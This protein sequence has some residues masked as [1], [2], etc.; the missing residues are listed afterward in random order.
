MPASSFPSSWPAAPTNGTPCLSSW[1]PGASPTN[2]RS[3]VGEPE[4]KTTCVRRLRERAARAAGD[5]VARTRRAVSS[6]AG[7]GVSDSV[8]ATA[9]AAAA[10]EPDRR[11]SC[12]GVAVL[13]VPVSAANTENC[14]CTFA[15]PQSGHVGRLVVADELLEVRLAAHADV[16]VD[17]HRGSNRTKPLPV[18]SHRASCAPSRRTATRRYAARCPVSATELEPEMKTFATIAELRPRSRRCARATVGLVPTMGALHDGHVALFEAARAECDVVVASLF[19]N[20]AQFATRRPRRVPARPRRATSASPR[21]RVSTSSS[22]RRPTS[23]IRPASRPGSSRRGA[24][25]GLE[26]EHRPGHFRGVATVCLK[27]FTIVRP[28]RRVLRPQGR[29]AGRGREAGRARPE[30]RARDPRRPDRARRRRARALVAQRAALAPTSARARSRSRARSRRA[31][32][33]APARCSP[34]PGSSPTTSPSPTST[35]RRSRSPPASARP[36]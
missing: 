20:P 9:S 22:R 17:R 14:R 16:F 7:R 25:E 12:R 31:T 32:R 3:A 24:A 35:G 21:T 29:A 30:P 6:A 1:K 8:A 2:I 19:V 13:L 26:G 23:S 4:P 15:V 28:A 34:T 18:T 11:R 5:R 10:A 33:R 36:A 27:L